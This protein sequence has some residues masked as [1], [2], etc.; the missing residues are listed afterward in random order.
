[1]TFHEKTYITEKGPP[2]M[3]WEEYRDI[4]VGEWAT[5][6]DDPDNQNKEP[7]FHEFFERH[8]C[9]LPIHRACYPYAIISKPRLTDFTWLEPDF[10]G[11][12]ENSVSVFVYLIE[13]EA[14]GKPW[15]TKNGV[16]HHKLTEAINQI[17]EWK[18]HF[19][20]PLNQ[21]Q[22]KKHY[23]FNDFHRTLVFE[24]R[25]ILIYGRREEATKDPRLVKKRAHL[26]NPP[27]EI[28][29]TYDRLEP[30]HSL[31]DHLTVKIDQDGYRAISVPPTIEL[32]PI[33]ADTLSKIRDKDLAVTNCRY[34]SEERI[35]FLAR[36]FSYWDDWV[37]KTKGKFQLIGPGGE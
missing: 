31:N 4:V 19:G 2:K 28:F 36:R 20:D 29:M 1:M 10:M 30:I 35:A 17:K 9:M 22:F 3:N 23:F 8:P 5:L 12:T 11:I 18:T 32:S 33:G 7:V 25:Y 37:N 26:Q 13:I 14:P 15:F 16:Q 6:L 24:P 27:N 21:E 34:L